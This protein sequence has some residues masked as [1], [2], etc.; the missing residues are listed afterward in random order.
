VGGEGNE[1]CLS[2][3]VGWRVRLCIVSISL[4]GGEGNELCLSGTVGWRV[5][6]CIVSIS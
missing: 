2:G 6:L 1:L 3:T 4:V 5:R